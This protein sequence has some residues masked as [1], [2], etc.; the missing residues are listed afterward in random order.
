VAGDLDGW[1]AAGFTVRGDRIGLGAVEVRGVLA[2]SEEGIVAWSLTGVGDGAVDG[3]LTVAREEA[4]PSAPPA[5][6]NR[7]VAIDHLVVSSPDLDRTT[8]ALATFGIDLRRTR[9]AGRM[10]QRF[11]RLGE[12]VLELVGRPGATGPGPAAF[13]GLALTVDDLEATADLLG[14]HL[15]PV[16]EAVQPGRRIATLR[17]EAVGVSVPVAFLSP[18]PPRPSRP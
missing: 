12:V 6:P 3:L 17:H 14:E 13:W 5:H 1:A 11:F 18:P 9:D 8:Q 16:T 7:T 2:P 10:E 15:G 4:D